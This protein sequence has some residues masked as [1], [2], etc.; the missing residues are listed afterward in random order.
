TQSDIDKIVNRC[1]IMGIDIDKIDFNIH[2]NVSY[3]ISE[4]RRVINSANALKRRNLKEF[5]RLQEE[6]GESLK[7]NYGIINQESENIVKML[8][9]FNSVLASRILGPGSGANV[10]VWIK[11]GESDSFVKQ[12]TDKYPAIKIIP[13]SPGK[14]A[15]IVFGGCSIIND[16]SKNSF[17]SK[18]GVEEN[19][20][21][22]ITKPEDLKKIG[23][24]ERGIIQVVSKEDLVSSFSLYFSEKILP[25]NLRK[26]FDELFKNAMEHGNRF[27]ENKKVTIEWHI[28]NSRARIS[29]SDEGTY[30]FHPDYYINMDEERVRERKSIAEDLFD[31]GDLFPVTMSGA[32]LGIYYAAKDSD[33]ICFENITDAKG[34]KIGTKVTIIKYLQKDSEDNIPC[35]YHKLAVPEEAQRHAEQ[36]FG[37]NWTSKGFTLKDIETA[38]KIQGL[39]E[40]NAQILQERLTE[41]LE[42][43]TKTGP[44]EITN[45][46]KEILPQITFYLTN[47]P[48]KLGKDP[49][50]GLPYI[51][52]CKI[53]SKE[54][55]FHVI[56]FF[57]QPLEK[58]IEILY[59]ELISHI[60]KGKT[61][62][63]EAMEDTEEFFAKLE[64]LSEEE[65]RQ[66]ED[67]ARRRNL[68]ERRINELLANVQ[69]SISII[70]TGLGE[71]FKLRIKP[72]DWWS[73]DFEHNTVIFPVELLLSYSAEQVV[74]FSS[75]E[76]GHRQISRVDLRE[77][78]FRLFFSKEDLRLLL[79]T[80]EDARVNNWIQEQFRGLAYYLGIIYD[81][82]LPQ[83]PKKSQYVESLQR[84][85]SQE[86]KETIHPYQLYPHLEYLLGVL[87]YWRYNK[88]PPEIINPEVREALERTEQHFQK[89]FSHYP[90]GRVSEPQKYKLAHQTAEMVR[91]YILPEYEKLV[92][93]A[94]ERLSKAIKEGEI[95]VSLGEGKDPS[96]LNP[97]DLDQE[98]QRLIE[99]KAKEL[100][101]RLS[102]KIDR[103]DLKKAEEY[104][105]KQKAGESQQTKAPQTKE[106]L[107][108]P[109]SKLKDLIR[110][111]IQLQKEIESQIGEYERIS[112]LISK[113][114]QEVTGILENYLNKTRKPHYEGYFTSGQKPDLRR[115]MDLDRKQKLSQPISPKD[116]KIMLKRRAPKRIDHRFV[117]VLDESGSMSEPKRTSALSG[118]LLFME[119]LSNLDI[120]YC[121]IGFSDTPILHKGFDRWLTPEERKELFEEVSGYIP[122]GCTADS[123][124][125]R[126][127]IDI[128]K[129][130]P[131]DVGRFIIMITDGE[132]NINTT[133]KTLE[134]LQQEA[135]EESIEVMGV[136]LGEGI[137]EVEKHYKTSIQVERPEELPSVLRGI[138]EERIG[139]KFGFALG[140]P[141]NNPSSSSPINQDTT[142]SLERL[143]SRIYLHLKQNYPLTINIRHL[144]RAGELLGYL[145]RQNISL[146]EA[147]VRALD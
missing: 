42:A 45:R 56:D 90:K 86:Q 98:A 58:Q 126:L 88:L 9:K 47:D 142:Q 93:E 118:L 54:V 35:S 143:L 2:G 41:L 137:N 68:D 27:D 71:D 116:Q 67:L 5:F 82:L 59:H 11:S 18:F 111:N 115:A 89:I 128:L 63:E 102:P 122:S 43:I 107:Y 132:G 135:R 125:L 103:P 121:I 129:E 141:S 24:S 70:S 16:S 80:F 146:K 53:K 91:E 57:N 52:S 123:D 44:P 83:D 106:P 21:I 133:G 145:L 147:L 36:K 134:E 33:E 74:G 46:F 87:Y 99:Q 127:A 50:T 32:G 38:I 39:S 20:I 17:D 139:P 75:H 8:R 69:K 84:E 14:G 65:R 105:R 15:D 101:E 95:K 49:K 92:N 79:N 77:D 119:A 4:M 114:L 7:N 66:L 61:N 26:A 12:I 31:S 48:Q 76:A 117:L 37:K 112:G 109:G 51:A 78:L 81:D 113:L 25:Q 110:R 72:G 29:I 55:Y 23:L 140:G 10:M 100:S 3:V 104:Q 34:N 85:I 73:Y 30:Y 131:Y 108:Q 28:T 124:A 13:F 120:D 62:E 144:K 138:L 19:E 40:E 60:V 97:G 136:G 1:K 64:E 6:T 130:E 94:K 22:T 96:G